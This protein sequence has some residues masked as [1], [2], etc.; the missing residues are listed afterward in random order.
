MSCLPGKMIQ[1]IIL[2]GLIN[3]VNNLTELNS[4]HQGK[5]RNILGEGG[6]P[7]SGQRIE[8]E[9]SRYETWAN[10]KIAMIGQLEFRV[11]LVLRSIA[12]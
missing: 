4:T 5:S 1:M 8:D 11:W 3:L 12:R 2:N 6:C 10:D 7:T 9:T